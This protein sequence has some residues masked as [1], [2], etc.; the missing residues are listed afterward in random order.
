MEYC[1]YVKYKS[2]YKD[3]TIGFKWSIFSGKPMWVRP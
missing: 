2:A 3:K 1:V